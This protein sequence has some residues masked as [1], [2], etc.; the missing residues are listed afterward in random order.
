MISASNLDL[1]QPRTSS[2]N[3]I[4]ATHE[5]AGKP[6]I[7]TIGLSRT[8]GS[9]STGVTALRSVDLT[10]WPGEFVAIL[11]RS[12]S[13]KSTLLS[14]LGFLDLPTS[15]QYLFG[16]RDSSGIGPYDRAILRN[17]RIGFVF[18]NSHLLPRYTARENVE[19]ALIYAG[20][21]PHGRSQRAADALAAV[22]LQD[23]TQHRP[24]E[25]SGGEQQRVALARAMV[26]RP[27][28]LLA[29][30]PTG[31]LDTHT[32]REVMELFR[33]LN[34]AGQTI[35][36][37][38]HDVELARYADRAVLMRDGSIIDS[39]RIR[40]SYYGKSA[41]PEDYR[42][43]VQS[44]SSRLKEAVVSALSTLRAN[45]V[46]SLLTALGMVVGIA[47]VIAMV[48]IGD[49]A[50]RQVAEQIESLG[51][52]LLLV[53][54]G[55]TSKQGVHLGLG[56]SPSLTQDDAE[57]IARQVDGVLVAAPTVTGTAQVV[58]GRE[59]WSTLIG[60]VI[61]DYL[62]A[63]DWQIAWGESVA[64]TDLRNAS[65]VALLGT[66]VAERLFGPEN[67]LNQI[68]RIGKTPFRVKG[69]L[70]AKG[71]DAASGRDQDDVV[72]IPL[73][74]AKLRILGRSGI[75]RR[76][77]DFIVLKSEDGA[78]TEMA[79]RV[80]HLLRQRH[81]IPP[82]AEDDFVLRDPAATLNAREDSLHSLTLL[83]LAVACVS[84]IVG[85]I[86]IM[87]TLLV[88]TVERRSEIALR[89]AIGA[90]CGDIR[91]QFLIEAAALCLLGSFAGLIV[92]VGTAEIIAWLLGWQVLIQLE[93]VLL[94][95]GIASL[96]GLFFGW[97]PAQRA[98]QMRSIYCELG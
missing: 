94:A 30:E 63:R 5:R 75:D 73:S 35:V 20:V 19:L 97:Y 77:V 43:P 31:A 98:S 47:A 52:N 6:L 61:P 32:G 82:D 45:P 38:T 40:D 17:H 70:A 93:V 25:L 54:P 84:L 55:S 10:I 24:A 91:N 69:V 33:G 68:I 57:S 14:L 29:D 64:D 50:R 9:R 72:L 90:T 27:L 1:L 41:P 59:N 87:N 95:I 88:S 53:L 79:E 13:G 92:G 42:A 83:L 67:P 15:G 8:Y 96:I 49:G 62:L 11:G 18:Q 74:T 66:T 78:I 85:G 60:G 36:M 86:G 21:Y 37:V 4:S 76:S 48:A 23:R 12:G 44:R 34:E 80:A 16:E 26:N 3:S 51:T 28:L 7:R 56:S 65:K 58:R 71:Q 22:G 2:V 39:I 89:M 81:R 46:R